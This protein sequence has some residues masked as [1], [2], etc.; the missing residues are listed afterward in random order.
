[1]RMLVTGAAGFIGSH[2]VRSL[3]T[4]GFADITPGGQPVTALTVIDS[5]GIDNGRTL[6]FI[7]HFSLTFTNSTK[8]N[9]CAICPIGNS[10]LCRFQKPRQ[11]TS[12]E[13]WQMRCPL[14][15]T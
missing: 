6:P 8:F 12:L 2:Y 9:R 4:S 3:L 7:F 5:L 10:S 14:K 11:H 1:M 15:P 13:L